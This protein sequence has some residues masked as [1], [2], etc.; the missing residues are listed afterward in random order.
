V[1]L[2]DDNIKKAFDSIHAEESLKKN[3]LDFLRTKM[4]QGV[5]E[6][7]RARFRRLT[8]AMA[9]CVVFT[10]IGLFSYN[11][12]FSEAMYVDVDINPSI[13]LTVNRLDRVIGVYAYNADGEAL[14]EQLN[15]LHKKYDEAVTILTDASMQS[16]FLEDGG[17]VSVT[18]QSNSS[19]D[20]D[21]KL[22]ALEAD[23]A[24]TV[25][26][27]HAEVQVNAFVVDSD[28]RE[29]AHGQNL[30]PAKYLAILA[31]QDVDPTATMESCRDHTIEE[32]YTLT[33]ECSDGHHI[34]DY[35]ATPESETP[36]ATNSTPG[37][38]S[39]DNDHNGNG[40]E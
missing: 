38:H 4:T 25:Q 12:Y 28:T 8:V 26:N 6:N 22:Q 2:L 23:I 34:E 32:I 11:M 16:G 9:C 19:M 5:R 7:H 21:A 17:L 13:E 39:H 37:H 18:L 24:L 33:E 1:I 15:L 29:H 10:F 20:K 31:L 36:N 30:S 3:T 14:L 35:T 40:H 27:H